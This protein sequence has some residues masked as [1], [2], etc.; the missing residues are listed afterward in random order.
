MLKKTLFFLYLALLTLLSLLPSDQLPNVML[1]P[2]ADKL[3]H[4]CMY[5]GLTFLLFVAWPKQF[6]GKRAFI[7]LILV[8]AWGFFME[9]M[10]RYGNLG[11]SFDFRDEMSNALGFFPGWLAWL[12][13]GKWF[14]SLVDKLFSRRQQA[15]S[16]EK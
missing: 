5:A 7:P 10:Q 3:I 2:N 16:T 4:I 8:I 13:F 1:F 9:F 15:N 12:W 6:S 14:S 11:R